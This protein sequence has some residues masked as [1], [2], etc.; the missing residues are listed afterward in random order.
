MLHL[1]KKTRVSRRERI[2]CRC[3]ACPANSIESWQQFV[4]TCSDIAASTFSFRCDPVREFRTRISISPLYRSRCVMRIRKTDMVIWPQ[5][6]PLPD[7]SRIKRSICYF[8]TS[9]FRGRRR[10]FPS[11]G[12]W[13]S[14]CIT[15]RYDGKPRSSRRRGERSSKKVSHLNIRR[16]R[17][18]S[19]TDIYVFFHR[20]ETTA[21]M[22][23]ICFQPL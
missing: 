1:N 10:N 16:A 11:Q 21:P 2:K 7:G 15:L 6:A 22:R 14:R 17:I 18:K 23:E 12:R 19:S 5:M 8:Y 4:Y 20:Q 13:F 9:R 3:K